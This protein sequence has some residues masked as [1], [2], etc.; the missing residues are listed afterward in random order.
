[1]ALQQRLVHSCKE[2]VES[3]VQKHAGEIHTA[4]IQ[5]APT[6]LFFSTVTFFSILQVTVAAALPPIHGS[7]VRQVE[8]TLPSP[9]VQ[10]ALK[11]LQVATVENTRKW[12]PGL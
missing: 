10:V 2:S 6:H 7:G 4:N 9:R 1:M 12:M 5:G 11:L 3:A 8:E